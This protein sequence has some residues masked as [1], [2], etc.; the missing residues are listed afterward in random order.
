MQNSIM[1]GISA[2]VL[3][4]FYQDGSVNYGEFERLVEYITDN[5]VHGIFVS[6][7]TGEFINLTIDERK[8]LLVSA[9]KAAKPGTKIMFN[10]TAMNLQELQELM[11][12]AA[13]Q[14]VDAVSVTAPYYHGYDAKALI[15]YFQHAAEMAKGQPVYL[16][17]MA[18][19]TRNPISAAV[20]KAV[21]ESCPN[22]KGIKDSSMDFMVLLEY[23]NAVTRKDFEIITGNDAQVLSALQA[24]ADGGVIAVASVFPQ[25]SMEVWDKYQS[26]DLV[27]ARAAQNKILKLRGLYRDIMPIMSHK[28]TLE[29]LGF[30]MGP[31]RFPFRELT[32]QERLRVHDTIKELGLL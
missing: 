4:P 18:V 30:S 10:T 9:Q 20:L 28:A 16:Y 6:G 14:K 27:G 24:E 12:F 32:E 21:V 29:L 13:E 7:T 3:T 17:N 1:R 26:G 22:V 19:M 15:A 11:D 8:K 25:L 23:Q 2:P 5:G 31:A